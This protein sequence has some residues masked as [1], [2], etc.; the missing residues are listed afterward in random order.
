MPPASDR[1]M[2]TNQETTLFEIMYTKEL[3]SNNVKAA[4]DH[5]LNWELRSMSR[6]TADEIDAV[7]E[8][9]NRAIKK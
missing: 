2:R 4:N 7:R 1:E 9:V 3:L 5:L 8:R 6:M